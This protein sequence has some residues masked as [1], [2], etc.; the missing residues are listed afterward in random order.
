LRFRLLFDLVLLDEA[1]D[2]E[3]ALDHENP[4]LDV[5][6]HKLNIL[7]QLLLVVR[8]VLDFEIVVNPKLVNLEVFDWESLNHSLL[9]Y[10]HLLSFQHRF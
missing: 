4:R 10:F 9:D 5:G 6:H 1:C 2:F 3:S 8:L 7:E